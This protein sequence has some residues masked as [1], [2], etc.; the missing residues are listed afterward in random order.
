MTDGTPAEP[1]PPEQG[2]GA[3][4]A[5]DAADVGGYSGDSAPRDSLL[6]L[7]DGTVFEGEAMGAVVE[8]ATGE[9]VFNTLLAGY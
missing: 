9:L 2:V 6:V 8:V 3:P 7:A 5:G 4:K 1:V